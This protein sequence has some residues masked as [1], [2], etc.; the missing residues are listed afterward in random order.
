MA[1]T[2]VVGKA[3]YLE[4]VAEDNSSTA[5]I[6]V[7]PQYLDSEGNLQESVVMT[8]EVSK[9]YPRRQWNRRPVTY[10]LKPHQKPD[11]PDKDSFYAD[12]YSR[13]EW[14]ALSEQE[15]YESRKAELNYWLSSGVLYSRRLWDEATEQYKSE[16]IQSR[17]LRGSKP[18]SV[19][20]TDLDLAELHAYK[21]PQAVIRRINKVRDSLAEYPK[22]LYSV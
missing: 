20:V 5:Q 3:L 22:E 4:L 16:A 19:E 2:K 17:K 7:F 18:F 13:D 21:T 11:S 15:K 9:Y 10:R 6:I 1:T 14:K 12:T 8:R